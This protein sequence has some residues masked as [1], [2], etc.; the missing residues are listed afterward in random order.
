V[1]DYHGVPF[2]R[3]VTR[4]R[5]AVTAIDQA[6][7]TGSLPT[8][9]A[10][11]E[12]GGFPLGVDA[13]RSRISLYVA[14]LTDKT[15]ELTGTHADGWL[16]IWPSLSGS[17][18]QLRALEKAAASAHRPRPAVAAYLYGVVGS[19]PR[20]FDHLRAT[21][22]WYVAANGTAYRRLFERYGYVDEVAR[23]SELWAAGRRDR[24]RLAV[25]DAMLADCT[26]H[27]EPSEVLRQASRFRSAGITRPVLRL[28]G[29]LAAAD[30]VR[31]LTALAEE[32]A[33]PRLHTSE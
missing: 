24:A 17:A 15:L 5:E 25:T 3:P 20:L 27:G 4:L 14:G 11:F 13:D 8:G 29:Q 10:V 12:L 21:L 18:E 16:P 23:I 31:M 2:E 22:A 19:A 30:C 28:P 6:F 26:L 1:Q 9:G 32:S 33:V 7:S